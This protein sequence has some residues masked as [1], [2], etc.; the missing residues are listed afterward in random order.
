M[1]RGRFIVIDGCEGSGKST[2]LKK[3]R[4]KYP[5]AV[6]TREPGGSPYG[7]AIREL[8]LYHPEAKHADDA[9]LLLLFYAARFDHLRATVLPAL[10]EGKDVITDRFD[11]TT[12]SYQ[13][14]ARGSGVLEPLFTVLREQSKMIAEPDAYIFLDIDPEVGIARKQTQ[15]AAGGDRFNH[16]DARERAFHDAACQG[17]HIFA[18]RYAKHSEII[19]AGDPLETVFQNLIAAI[20]RVPAVKAEA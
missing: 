16:L 7:E 3:L 12:F 2:Q 15:A 18:E 17:F 4:E 9:T 11:S 14:H 1:T 13:I 19:N 6:F 5:N 20:E 10:T 8:I